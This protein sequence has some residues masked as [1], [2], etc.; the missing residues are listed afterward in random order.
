MPPLLALLSDERL[1][2]CESQS[3]QSLIKTGTWLLS[4]LCQYTE[5]FELVK[6]CLPR[7]AS[8]IQSSDEA[9]LKDGCWGIM[10]MCRLSID[11]VVASGACER[12]VHLLTHNSDDVCCVA[13]EALS[14]IFAHGVKEHKKQ[15]LRC[16]V[17]PRLRLLL[18]R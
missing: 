10:Y 6:D 5:D 12:L 9:V 17:L 11:A 13:M 16:D 8:L 3:E 15:I 18:H 1:L 7:L 2:H 4:N 14:T